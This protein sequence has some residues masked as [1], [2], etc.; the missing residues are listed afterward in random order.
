MTYKKYVS[1]ITK[2]LGEYKKAIDK[3]VQEYKTE[4]AKQKKEIEEM[5]GK[6]TEQYIEEYKQSLK[7]ANS[8]ASKMGELRAKTAP[9]VSHYLELIE[10]QLNNYFNAPI[11]TEFANRINSIAITGLALSD[12]EFKILQD[13][14][15]SYMER[16]LLN[17]LAES[18][19]KEERRAELSRETGEVAWKEEAVS[20]PY[21]HVEVPNIEKMY[22]AF[23]EYK[24]NA[25]YLLN[26]YS[27]KDAELADCLENGLPA[28][29]SITSDSYFRN[30]CEN[31]FLEVMNKANSILPESKIKRE[32]TEQDKK[33]IDVLI[34]PR[35][36][37]LA[38]STVAEISANS[39][40]L[41]ELFLLDS[42]Y[43]NY[44]PTGEEE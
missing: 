44:V 33:L 22:D 10:K 21:I 36:P 15:V 16:R 5:H 43:A 38:K 29:M 2:E 27:G 32:L 14:A 6:Y 23:K 28:Y 18:R 34:D 39:P 30:E 9:I 12:T 20:N 3:L 4:Q 42:R 40:E 17:Q 35:Y 25:E 19:K 37:N 7:A 26:G 41:A 24:R 11:R 1:R 31:K 8:Y 13:S